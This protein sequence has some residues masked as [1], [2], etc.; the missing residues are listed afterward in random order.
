MF[1]CLGFQDVK[2]WEAKRI[3]VLILYALVMVASSRGIYKAI[4]APV[5]NRERRELAE[6]YMEAL[7]PEPT[8]TNVRKC[9]LLFL[10]HLILV[11]K[12]TISA[13]TEEHMT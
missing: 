13:L 1:S 8:P 6:A 10:S 7:I 2:N 5:I 9:V 11:W 12:S 3:G 4:Q